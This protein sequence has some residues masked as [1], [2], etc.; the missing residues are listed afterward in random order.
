ML[1]QK[2]YLQDIKKW[3]GVDEIELNLTDKRLYLR[4]VN[5]D[6]TLSSPG[7]VSIRL[8]CFLSAAHGRKHAAHELGSQRAHGGPGPH[9]HF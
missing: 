6:E 3:L 7:P 1:I 8:Q 4:T 2:K 9:P 5:G